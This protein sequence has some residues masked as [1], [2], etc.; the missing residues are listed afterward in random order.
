M[1][2]E[3]NFVVVPNP[4]RNPRLDATRGGPNH[5][6]SCLLST[7]SSF[8]E[9]CYDSIVDCLL[10]KAFSPSTVVEKNDRRG[11]VNIGSSIR[12][13]EVGLPYGVGEDN[14]LVNRVP[15]QSE[16]E[17]LPKRN[18]AHTNIGAG[19]PNIK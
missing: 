4:H 9:S 7:E 5:S 16:S 10:L 11:L 8:P 1:N 18:K 3:H 13:L 12:Y 14:L 6:S 2:P 17:R 19:P 15:P